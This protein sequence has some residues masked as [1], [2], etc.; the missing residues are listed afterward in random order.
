MPIAASL[1][2]AERSMAMRRT[3]VS[4]GSHA[5]RKV[6][7]TVAPSWS[8]PAATPRAKT[9]WGCTGSSSAAPKSPSFEPK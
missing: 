7:T 3:R 4:G 5:S 6:R 1:V 8:G 2:I 9:S